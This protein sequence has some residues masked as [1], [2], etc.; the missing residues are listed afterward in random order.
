MGKEALSSARESLFQEVGGV[1][2]SNK[3][4]EINGMQVIMNGL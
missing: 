3:C 2:G 4:L 1:L